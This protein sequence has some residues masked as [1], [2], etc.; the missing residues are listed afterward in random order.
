M[1]TCTCNKFKENI[2][3]IDGC[4][5][6]AFIHGMIYEGT[7]F[8]YCPWCGKKLTEKEKE[9]KKQEF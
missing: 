6:Y 1:F 8:K 2:E 5:S 9:N 4:I 3:K 7:P